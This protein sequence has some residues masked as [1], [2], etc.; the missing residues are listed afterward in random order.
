MRVLLFLL[1][2]GVGFRPGH[3]VGWS[4]VTGG[5]SDEVI[6]DN[7]RH[8]SGD[9]NFNPPDVPGM[10]FSN[11]PIAVDTPSIMDIGPTVLDLFGVAIPPYCDGRSLL[12]AAL[13]TAG[14]G[15]GGDTSAGTGNEAG[16]TD[17]GSAGAAV[18]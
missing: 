14:A 4:S 17:T 12:P 2:L 6:E 15:H 11:R 9:H 1:L 3:R 5:L 7:T 10:L 16:T 8:W 18:R 13:T